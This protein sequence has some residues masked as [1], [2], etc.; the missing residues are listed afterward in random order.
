MGKPK[1]RPA[2][3][4]AGK[5]KST[6]TQRG[7][8]TASRLASA[9]R[10]R[11]PQQ[12]RAGRPGPKQQ[13]AP[14]LQGWARGQPQESPAHS[15]SGGGN[16][17]APPPPP[18]PPTAPPAASPRSAPPAA[19]VS[20]VAGRAHMTGVSCTSQ[21]ASRAARRELGARQEP[22]Q[23]EE[24]SSGRA[25][26]VTGELG[27]LG[28]EAV[29]AGRV[30][31][32]AAVGTV[33]GADVVPRRAAGLVLEGAV[34]AAATAA[35][36]VADPVFAGGS[37]A[38]VGGG[39]TSHAAA[40]RAAQKEAEEPSPGV[41]QEQTAEAVLS[42]SPAPVTAAVLAAVVSAAAGEQGAAPSEVDATPVPASAGTRVPAAAA[43]RQER[44]QAEGEFL[45]P[46]N[47]ASSGAALAVSK[48]KLRAQPAPRRPGAGL[49]PGSPGPLLGWLLQGQSP[50]E[51]AHRSS[52]VSQ[53]EV[54][55]EAE[56][57]SRPPGISRDA[58]APNVTPA[59]AV[60]AEAPNTTNAVAHNTRHATGRAA[61][62]WGPPRRGR[63][64]WLPAGRG[65]TG[66]VARAP[67]SAGRT[68]RGGGAR[69]A[70]GGRGGRALVG[71]SE[72]PVQVGTWRE[73][74]DRPEAGAALTNEEEAAGSE[75]NGGDPEFMCGD[76]AESEEVSLE[77]ETGVDRNAPN[78]RGRGSRGDGQNQQAVGDTGG[79][80]D[81]TDVFSPTDMAKDE[82]IW[83]EAGGW[84]MQQLQR[85]DQPFLV[86]RLPP[87]ILDKYSLCLLAPLLR[88]EK[89]PT[90][91][92]TR[93]IPGFS[94]GGTHP[95]EAAEPANG[96][97]PEPGDTAPLPRVGPTA[98]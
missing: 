38:A 12:G 57:G 43:N 80:M 52:S 89:F 95:T 69:G 5:G 83:Q 4:G 41:D 90:C 88:L 14:K 35:E 15:Q 26:S 25:G 85:S 28:D 29:A 30:G 1:P 73:R 18:P 56:A 51:R 58:S 79:A 84:D 2:T 32:N 92:G 9:R 75:D 81:A 50:S 44:G 37:A 40:P 27:A 62:T 16:A 96:L 11:L 33:L 19:P 6:A 31:E 20:R 55:E 34:A 60:H 67:T 68:Q 71:G 22:R 45:G 48:K 66:V 47:G 42:A 98:T 82:A 63:T 59:T 21:R 10:T 64:P 74:H 53:R 72:I 36:T 49:G 54:R 65:A 87:Q 3:K 39:S 94:H 93:G 61:I 8:N 76:E 17:A 86:R 46:A 13:A 78:T 97:P 7:S 70:R 24:A 23:G 91:L 77:E